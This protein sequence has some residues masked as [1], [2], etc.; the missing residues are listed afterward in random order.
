MVSS[1]HGGLA[2][3]GT[4][5]VGV[6][7]ALQV[8]AEN[9]GRLQH[10]CDA[11]LRLEAK[12]RGAGTGEAAHAQAAERA[13]AAQLR[14]HF[15][16]TLAH[17]HQDEEQDLFPALLESMAGSDAVCIRQMVDA[18]AAE[19]REIEWRWLA[20]RQ[21]LEQVETG[22]ADLPPN[23]AIGSFVS[24]YRSHLEQEDQE[25]LPMAQRLLSDAALAQIE[26]AMRR[27]RGAG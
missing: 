13:A 11:L 7:A 21:W 26:E 4:W 20:L 24:L 10:E 5:P 27:R 18:R 3:S 1:A 23:G 2:G 19:H 17:L 22:R 15:D 6:D 25:L 8:L 14:R 9:H 16:K 12:L